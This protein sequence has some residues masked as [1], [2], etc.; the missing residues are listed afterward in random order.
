VRGLSALLAVGAASRYTESRMGRGWIA[1]GF[2]MALVWCAPALA[3]AEEQQALP[4]ISAERLGDADAPDPDV[5]TNNHYLSPAEREALAAQGYNLQIDDTIVTQTRI[6]PP[7]SKTE[8]VE[9]KG[10]FGRAM[11]TVGKGMIAVASVAI[12]L[13]AAVAPFFLF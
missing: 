12:P 6:Q 1:V 10:A 5:D 2:G 4:L 7:Q 8:P 3:P 13:A 9:P 11:D